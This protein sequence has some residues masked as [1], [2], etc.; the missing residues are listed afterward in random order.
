LMFGHALTARLRLDRGRF[1]DA[2]PPV[3]PRQAEDQGD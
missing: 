2:L 1:P 3:P